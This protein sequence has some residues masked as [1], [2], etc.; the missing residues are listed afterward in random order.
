MFVHTLKR[1]LGYLYPPHRKNRK[2]ILLYHSI[3]HHPWAVSKASFRKQINWLHDHCRIYS[4]SELLQ[5]PYNDDL[6]IAI[7]FDDGYAS[8]YDNA[9]TIL[10]NKKIRPLV[11][12]N[13]H[14]VD[15]QHRNDAFNYF[16]HYEGEAFLTW[17]EVLEL[18]AHHWEI[19]SHAV[20]HCDFSTLDAATTIR[21]LCL[22]KE[23]IESQLH[24]PCAHFSYPWG[25]YT[26]DAMQAVKSAGY[27]SAVGVRHRCLTP[28]S[29]LFALPR[30][31]I[32]SNYSFK[33]FKNIMMGKWD[34]L[35]LIHQLKGL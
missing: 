28:Q 19:G 9:L 22:S 14:W 12:L 25:K 26:L 4:F 8:L 23:R 2:I 11:Y 34:Y 20:N 33:D 3:G 5:T 21:E 27:A 31:N 32:A 15:A 16:G 10:D 18:S 17:P 6:Q 24:K 30:I 1:G 13:T 35:N 7:T 29:P